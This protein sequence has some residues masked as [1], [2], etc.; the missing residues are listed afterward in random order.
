VHTQQQQHLHVGPLI[1]STVVILFLYCFCVFVCAVEVLMWTVFIIC[2][3]SVAVGQDAT[4]VTP[5]VTSGVGN[6][7]ITPA[8]TSDVGGVAHLTTTASSPSRTVVYLNPTLPHGSPL[9]LSVVLDVRSNFELSFRTCLRGSLLSQIG[10]EEQNYFH[11]V[12][13][14]SGSLNVSWSS[15]A[16]S[17]SVLLGRDLNDNQWYKFVWLYQ[18]LGNVTVSV[19]QNV[20]VLFS[21]TVTIADQSPWSL[22]LQN[23]SD[24]LVGDG[25][26]EGCLRDGPQTWFSSAAEVDNSAVEWHHCPN[27]TVCNRVVDS[28]SS[29]PC[30]NNGR[31]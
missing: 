22:N 12:L 13:D 20:S 6:V 7:T 1:N 8:V 23:G 28:C 30:A 5:T 17:K 4:V 27:E 16:A 10:G 2:T 18:D 25:Q 24:L 19:E 21:S 9:N 31:L 14:E 3:L 26:F 29:S 11:L 15:A